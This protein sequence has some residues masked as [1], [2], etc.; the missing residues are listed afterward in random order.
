MRSELTKLCETIGVR[1]E[2]TYGNNAPYDAKDDDWRR[3]AHPW[4]IVLR[5]GRR[6]LTVPFWTGSART[7]EPTAADVLGCLAS[8]ARLGEESF[9]DFCSD[10]GYDEDSRTAEKTW[11]ACRA[12]APRLRRFLGEHFDAVANAEH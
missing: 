5:L 9:H 8:D 7:D 4:T 10:I 12:T 3:T 11:K 1:A 6:R 2:V